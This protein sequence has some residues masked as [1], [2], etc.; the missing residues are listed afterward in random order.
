LVAA[1]M[2]WVSLLAAPAFAADALINVNTASQAELETLPGIGETKALAIIAHR[3]QNGPFATVD[4]LDDVSGIGPATLE[5]IRPLVSVGAG[6]ATPASAPPA[7]P[8]ATTSAT[9]PA[10]TSAAPPAT[11]AAGAI[12]INTA[13]VD[14]LQNLPGIGA[15]KA[16]AIVADRTQNGPFAACSDLDRVTGIGAAT[17]TNIGSMCTTK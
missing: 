8:P 11:P 17:I 12:N 16:A 14:E 1:L 15:T 13:S 10:T 2:F 4:Q 9:P 7:A 3:T 6:A 5:A